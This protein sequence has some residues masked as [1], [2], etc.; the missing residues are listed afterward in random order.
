MFD[1]NNQVKKHSAASLMTFF[2]VISLG[3]FKQAIG[4]CSLRDVFDVAFCDAIT[5]SLVAIGKNIFVS[6][7]VKYFAEFIPNI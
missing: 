2:N 5:S 6:C 3:F 4:L 7:K 1:R